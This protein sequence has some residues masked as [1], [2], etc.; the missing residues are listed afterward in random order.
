MYVSLS[1]YI[2]IYTHIYTC[3]YVY[4]YIS[5]SLYIYIYYYVM[6]YDNIAYHH[7][8]LYYIILWA[9]DPASFA[10]SFLG[11]GG[12]WYGCKPSSSAD[13]SNRAVRAHPPIDIRQE[14]VPSRAIRGIVQPHLLKRAQIT[15]SWHR[16]VATKNNNTRH[17][18]LVIGMS[19]IK[20][21]LRVSIGRHIPEH[22]SKP[23]LRLIL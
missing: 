11:D 15:Q 6:L 8:I 5:L 2:Y 7:V 20:N 16:E 10:N 4:V 1:L 3:V 22:P 21:P 12:G 19:R 18:C 9:A 17:P 13:F 23:H 14:T